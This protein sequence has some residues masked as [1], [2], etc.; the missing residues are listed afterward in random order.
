MAPSTC[1][2]L[3]LAVVLCLGYSNAWAGGFWTL[4]QGTS[5]FAR[6]GANIADPK[7]PVALYSNPAAMAGHRGLQIIVDSNMVFDFKEFSRASDSIDGPRDYA[8][9]Q[10][11]WRPNVPTPSLYVSYNLASIGLEQ[12]SVGAGVYGPLRVY[13]EWPD[14]GP[15]RYSQVAQHPLEVHYAMGAAYEFPVA[16]LRI[17]FTGM[18]ISQVVDSSLTLNTFLGRPEDPAWDAFVDVR[19]ADHLIPCG[20][21]AI[22]ASPWSWLTLSSSYQLPYDVDASGTAKVETGSE[23][24]QMLKVEGEDLDGTMNMPGILRAAALFAP[25]NQPY[26][27]EFAFVWENWSRYDQLIFTPKDIKIVP[28]PIYTSQFAAI[29]LDPIP[30]DT[31]WNDTYSLRLGGQYVLLE[32]SVTLRGGAFYEPSAVDDQ[33]RNAFSFDLDKI[34]FATGARVELPYNLWTDLAVGYIYGF[35]ATSKDSEAR[36]L[37]PLKKPPERKWPVGNG[38]YR[39]QQITAAIAVGIRFD[40]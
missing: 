4:D 3:A 5:A 22:S 18:L 12:M 25:D 6:G 21:L 36:I 35:E 11:G 19:A 13:S 28:Q 23:L 31:H 33:W 1:Q 26:E 8:T 40:V 7:E 39:S 20:I 2:C 15:Q 10:N 27:I 30:I 34:G 32:D 37:D 14:E 38:T 17:G 16:K 9:V 29:A 24:G